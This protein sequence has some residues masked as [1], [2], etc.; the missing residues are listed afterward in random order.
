MLVSTVA[1]LSLT[2]RHDNPLHV[3]HPPTFPLAGGGA[4]EI[5]HPIRSP[6]SPMSWGNAR[7]GTEKP[8]LQ[9]RYRLGCYWLGNHI[10]L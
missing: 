10:G 7:S 1:A 8:M 9:T 3:I 4:P 5:K 2:P 6:K